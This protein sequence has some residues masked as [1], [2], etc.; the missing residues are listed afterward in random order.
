MLAV[1]VQESESVDTSSRGIYVRVA[2]SAVY[3]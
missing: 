3:G 1:A 2:A